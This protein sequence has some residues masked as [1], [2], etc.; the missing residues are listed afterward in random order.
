MVKIACVL[1]EGFEESEAVLVVDIL[2]RAQ[3]QVDL[4]SLDALIVRSARGLQILADKPF[5]AMD[6]YDMI[7]LPGGAEGAKRLAADARVLSLLQRY[8]AQGKR[9]S[10]VCAAPAV[11]AKAGVLKHQTFTAHPSVLNDPHFEGAQAVM[12]S[13]V[14]SANIV[15]SRGLGTTLD[16]ALAL[17]D[18]LGGDAAAIADAIV[19]SKDL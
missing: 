6:D 1:A 11:L 9:L 13:V 19:Y 2:R 10:A 8:A 7:F 12:T 17:V 18:T 5:E 4:V 16:F 15:T 14:H 3:F